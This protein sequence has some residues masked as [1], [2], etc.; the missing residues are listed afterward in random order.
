[1]DNIVA[2]QAVKENALINE[3]FA[4]SGNGT[5][6]W[7]Q[8]TPNQFSANK[9]QSGSIKHY[10]TLNLTRLKIPN[11][12][13]ISRLDIN[14]DAQLRFSFGS[15]IYSTVADLFDLVA[16]NISTAKTSRAINSVNKLTT[17]FNY[18][19]NN[20]AKISGGMLF[21]G[22]ALVSPLPIIVGSGGMLFNGTAFLPDSIVGGIVFDGT[23]I[24]QDN[25]TYFASGGMLFDGTVILDGGTTLGI[26]TPT[27][28]S[29]FP[30]N[31]I[32][33]FEWVGDVAYT[34][35][36]VSTHN[37]SQYIAQPNTNG[38]PLLMGF[39]SATTKCL[40]YTNIAFYI[41]YRYIGIVT[42]TASMSFAFS[43]PGY[44]QQILGSI[45]PMVTTSNF[46]TNYSSKLTFSTP[47]T[48]SQMDNAVVFLTISEPVIQISAME[49]VL[50]GF[51]H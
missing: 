27:I 51:T 13:T 43:A 14:K 6:L 1:M 36:P 11:G 49:L 7:V 47:L 16:Q 26:N 46:Q 38:G 2:L 4:Q 21:N 31:F 41:A 3:I 15:D 34:A 8:N 24:V 44:S 5:L 39:S 18:W 23:A 30:N 20:T 33:S 42:P 22:T 17:V 50:T 25:S 28:Q 45:N 35:Q 48:Q 32:S 40:Y 29:V 37:D 9:T 19:Q 10:W 12:D